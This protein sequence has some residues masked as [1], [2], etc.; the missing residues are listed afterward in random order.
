MHIQICRKCI[1]LLIANFNC[2]TCSEVDI[3]WKYRQRDVPTWTLVLLFRCT[4]LSSLWSRR[5]D[6]K[7]LLENSLL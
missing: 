4:F 3:Y 7:E 6:R 5:R 1:A 2:I